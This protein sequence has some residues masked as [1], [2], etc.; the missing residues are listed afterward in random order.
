MSTGQNFIS[1]SLVGGQD[2]TIFQDIYFRA[3]NGSYMLNAA[4]KGQLD[5]NHSIQQITVSSGWIVDGISITYQLVDGGSTTIQHGTQHINAAV[6]KFNGDERLVGVYG[7]AGNQTYYKR[8]LVNNINFVIFD[9]AKGTTRT[10]GPFGNNNNS[11]EGTP[12][13]SSD[14]LAFG[15]FA[16]W[17]SSEPIGLQGLFFHKKM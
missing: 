9:T 14:V 13:Y 16:R 7:R 12:F 11:N 6:I 4:D 1:T 3:D 2:G 8:A 15:G 10:V 17:N 5:P